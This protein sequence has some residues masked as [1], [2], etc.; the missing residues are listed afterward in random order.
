MFSLKPLYQY[1][2]KQPLLNRIVF[3]IYGLILLAL[4]L[5]SGI[6]PEQYISHQDKV[7]H[8]LAYGIFTLLGARISSNIRIFTTLAIA[9][10]LYSGV[11]ELLQSFTGR[12][13]SGLDLLANGIG[14]IIVFKLIH[15]QSYS[16]NA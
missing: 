1:Q 13:M 14:V 9:I 15:L 4:S 7:G 3:I 2:Q 6:E 8:L 11:I 10:F 12:S 5:K 16:T